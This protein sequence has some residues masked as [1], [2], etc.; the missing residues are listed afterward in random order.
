MQ[1]RQREEDAWKEQIKKERQF[2]ELEQLFSK[3]KRAQENVLHIFQDAWQGNRS[4]QR[5]GLVEETMTEEWQKRKKQM[6]AV[7]DAIQE[8]RREHQRAKFASKEADAHAT[9]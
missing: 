4:R 3:A 5:L 2:E 6:Y 1:P 7:D 8:S 9:D